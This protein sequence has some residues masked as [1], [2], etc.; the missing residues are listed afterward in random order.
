VEG[1][2]HGLQ[3][4]VQ[5]RSWHQRDY[6]IHV[7]IDNTSVIHGL[8]GT[9]PPSSQASFLAF[10]EASKKTDV[11]IRWVPGHMGIQGNEEADSLARAG[12][13]ESP[14][15][16]WTTTYAGAR[17]LRRQRTNQQF[18][19]WWD[20]KH[21]DIYRYRRNGFSK[22]TLRCPEELS[23]P[24][25]TLHHLLALRS[26][27]GDFDWYHRK[28]NHP[29]N[30]PCSC[31]RV[32]TPEHIVH[33]SKISRWRSQWPKFDPQPY[34]LED[35]WDRLIKSPKQFA[36]FLKVTKFYESVCRPKYHRALPL[37][38]RE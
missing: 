16:T 7:C 30:D 17:A 22:A 15:R 1:A 8:Q 4:A 18:Q 26:G 11:T 5:Y 35:Y 20:L 34:T 21:R 24:R 13:K 32:R 29:N 28:F 31:G 23:L 19:D 37:P 14:P 3:H 38:L 12:A 27:H 25:P 33:C 2:C 10:Q 6:T 36:L 9:A